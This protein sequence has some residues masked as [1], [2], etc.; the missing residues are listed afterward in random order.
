ME[1]RVR[2]GEDSKADCS[3]FSWNG[4]GIWAERVEFFEMDNWNGFVPC[5]N[6]D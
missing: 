6:G 4:K 5:G 2:G 1:F 3:V